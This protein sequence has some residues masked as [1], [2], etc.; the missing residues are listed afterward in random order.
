MSLGPIYGKLGVAFGSATILLACVGVLSYRRVAQETIDQEW[1]EH[2]HLVLEQLAS[3]RGLLHDL[4]AR[5][6]AYRTMT[7][8]SF[9]T[10]AAADIQQIQEQARGL[11]ALTRDNANQQATLDRFEPLVAAQKTALD[12]KQEERASQTRPGSSFAEGVPQILAL[13]DEMITEERRLLTLRKTSALAAASRTRFAIVSGSLLAMFLF[14][15]AAF[16]VLREMRRRSHAEDALQAAKERYQVLFDANPLPVW[17]YDIETLKFLDVNP[18]AIANYGYSREEFAA[19]TIKEVRPEEDVPIVLRAV[20]GLGAHAEDSEVWKHRRHRKK[21]GTL[22]DVEGISHPVLYAGRNARF[23]VALDVTHRKIAEEALRLS[24]ER[25]RLIVSNVRDYAILMLDPEGRVVSWNEGAERIKGYKSGEIV[26]RH[27]SCFYPPEEVERGTPA[28]VLEE[29][30]TRGRC[31]NEG[32]RVRKDGSRFWANVVI[33]AL[34]DEAERLRGFA[35][36]TRDVSERKKYEEEMLRRSAELDA[37]N[38]ELEAFAYSVSHDLRAPLRGI[39]GFSQALLEDY[40]PQLDAT[41]KDYLNRVRAATQRMA[42]LIDDLL[43]LSRVTRAE[44]H[45]ERIDLS[46][47]AQ[48]IA[49]DL[50][51]GEPNR[52]TEVLVAPNLTAE[53][54]TRLVRVALENLLGNAWKFTS[55]LDHAKIEFAQSRSNGRGNGAFFVRDNGAGFNQAHANRLFGAFQ[56]LHGMS[57]FPGTGIGLATVQRI[58]HRHGGHVWAEGEVNKGATFYFTL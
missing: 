56:R 19:L 5:D 24:E 50:R 10:G 51:A 8:R 52:K 42:V 41:G 2:T 23:V 12:I 26:G 18:A 35:K 44:M 53:G 55:K 37:A 7:D 38:K 27:F 17:V 58:I 22:I 16:S 30:T 45:R 34:H 20:A 46:T 57:E 54:D 9:L 3:V 36:V 25:F 48:A 4:N 1:V 47:M 32:W 31:E 29:A 15:A 21:D 11:R 6:N 14:S 28:R 40:A 43:N 13:T 49:T 33:T 39:D